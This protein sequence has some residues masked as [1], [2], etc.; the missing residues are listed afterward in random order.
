MKREDFI[1]YGE[2]VFGVLFEFDRRHNLKNDKDVKNLVISGIK[3]T[4]KRAKVYYQSRQ[5]GFIMERIAN[6]FYDYHF[7]KILYIPIRRQ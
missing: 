6:I 2:F 3:R 4:G 7:K 5:E 1:K